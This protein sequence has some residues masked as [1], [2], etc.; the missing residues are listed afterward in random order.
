MLPT[1]FE[2]TGE[3]QP[4]GCRPDSPVSAAPPEL[5]P[6]LPVLFMA[7]PLPDVVDHDTRTKPLTYSR[8]ASSPLTILDDRTTPPSPVYSGHPAS[9][10]LSSPPSSPALEQQ[11]R[12]KSE[13]AQLP[14]AGVKRPASAPP[15]DVDPDPDA[16]VANIDEPPASVS[17]STSAPPARARARA[18]RRRS[19][20][21]ADDRPWRNRKKHLPTPTQELS[22]SAPTS[23]FTRLPVPTSAPPASPSTTTTPSFF[24]SS[25][26]PDDPNPIPHEADEKDDGNGD[27]H[28][29]VSGDECGSGA[30]DTEYDPQR[31]CPQPALLG[32]LLETLALSRA[33]SLPLT[34]L[35]RTTPALASYPHAALT[36]TVA[37]AVHARILGCVRSSGEAL[38][39]SYFYDP[40]ADP[41]RERGEL[42]RC[43]MPRAGKRRETMKYKQYYWAPV[44][45][46]RGRTRRWDV[47][48][49]E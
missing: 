19:D 5:A 37:W 48:W 1:P 24:S 12:R 25:P 49:E 4:H 35:T 3:Q 27:D 2:P 33:S 23:T 45:V 42:L 46:G 15:E 38:P 30:D 9:S 32:I 43:L 13:H 21:D 11:Q 34:A 8:A 10:P 14:G 47:D 44:V 18:K 31:P 26:T 36:S 29:E 16:T 7:S 41:D 22:A 20:V 17:T 28:S 40:A 6:G 39:P